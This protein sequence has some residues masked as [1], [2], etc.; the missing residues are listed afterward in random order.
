MALKS[1]KKLKATGNAPK[2]PER[3]TL[4]EVRKKYQIGTIELVVAELKEH[5]QLKELAR[6]STND[7]NRQKTTVKNAVKGYAQAEKFGPSDEIHI[8]DTAYKYDVAYSDKIDTDA[9]LK[10]FE[11]KKID[12]PTFLQCIGIAKDKAKLLIGAHVLKDIIQENIPGKTFD[13]RER[14][15]AT[16]VKVPTVVR[17]T[18]PP[19]KGN[20]LRRDIETAPTTGKGGVKPKRIRRVRVG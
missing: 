8:G 14:E 2:K 18:K 11:E 17:A 10:L 3:L 7:A 15:L 13:I 4:E 12:R 19:A 16:P 1:I 20:K 5:T 9:F 6:Q